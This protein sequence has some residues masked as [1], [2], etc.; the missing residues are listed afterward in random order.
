M[1][2]ST[3]GFVFFANVGFTTKC[4]IILMHVTLVHIYKIYVCARKEEESRAS[5]I[6][7]AVH[8]HLQALKSLIRSLISV[9]KSIRRIEREF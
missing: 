3:F 5:C 2:L 6:T 4:A 8:H 1:A 7:K 9:L